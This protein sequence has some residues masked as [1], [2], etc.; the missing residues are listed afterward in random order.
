[1]Y[2]ARL[3]TEEICCATNSRSKAPGRHT[4]SALCSAKAQLY[5]INVTFSISS[6]SLSWIFHHEIEIQKDQSVLF[7][8]P[9]LGVLAGVLGQVGVLVGPLPSVPRGHG[10]QA[11]VGRCLC[12]ALDPPAFSWSPLVLSGPPWVSVA[13]VLR[14]GMGGFGGQSLTQTPY[15]RT[16]TC[17]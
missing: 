14:E 6:H 7:L 9:C 16:Y 11:W 8:L 10:V 12:L 13:W 1:M 15:H 2:N 5:L 17:V 4:T 3:D